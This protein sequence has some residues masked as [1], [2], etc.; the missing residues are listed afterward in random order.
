MS[1]AQLSPSTRLYPPCPEE[2]VS[3]LGLPIQ[4]PSTTS[5]LTVTG[6]TVGVGFLAGLLGSTVGVLRQ[7]RG[8]PP[9][10]LATKGAYNAVLVAFPFF[11]TREYILNPLL[12][13]HLRPLHSSAPSNPHTD[14]LVTS[15]LAGFTT[16]IGSGMFLGVPPPAA[17]RLGVV[18]AALAGAGQF[19]TNEA[20]LWRKSYVEKQQQKAAGDEWNT[21]AAKRAI[22]ESQAAGASDR[23]AMAAQ[24]AT[25]AQSR[26]Q[27]AQQNHPSENK[28]I[29]PPWYDKW[30]PLKKLTDEQYIRRLESQ[31]RDMTEELQ[32]VAAEIEAI[33][34][35][36]SSP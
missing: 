36:Q 17:G 16:G 12:N 1:S 10:L 23:A 22:R 14:N 30:I 31:R 9:L 5:A 11:A 20:D 19:L 18:L 29:T 32:Q 26:Q 15:T 7:E 6:G 24:T 13:P 35:A 34:S 21:P 28:A 33:T 2:E 27:E 4:L 3:F 8:R 25:P